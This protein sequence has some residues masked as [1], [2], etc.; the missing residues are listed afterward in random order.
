MESALAWHDLQ[1]CLRRAPAKLLEAMKR[2]GSRVMIA[3]GYIRSCVANEAINDI[4]VF[5]PS[6]EVAAAL[7]MELAEGDPRKVSRTDNAYTVKRRGFPIQV[8]HRWTF[9]S[10]ED[11]L[12]SFDF[13]VAKAAIWCHEGKWQSVADS[14]FYPDLAAKRL[15]Y[16][17]P[18]R[19]ED[20]GGSALRLLKF[21]Q[22]G[23][24]SPLD[25]IGAVISRLIRG[26]HEDNDMFWNS[27]KQFS[28]V[29]VDAYRAKILTGLLRE[30]DPNVDPEHVAHLPSES[31]ELEEMES[32]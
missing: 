5:V 28:S 11:C 4:D 20:A 2:E 10:P 22:R 19:N 9:N 12:Q 8:I 3:G 24:R 29:E 13:T 14:R 26:V 32:N 7:S 16:T 1:W 15:V 31:D 23:Y 25:T 17:S 6:V 18:I 30:V 21:Y 27:R